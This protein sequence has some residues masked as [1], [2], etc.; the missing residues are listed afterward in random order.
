MSSD[1][2]F[3]PP[4]DQAVDEAAMIV[5]AID[6][7]SAFSACFNARDLA[8][9]DA[10]LHFPH[11]ILSGE[12][13]VV[14]DKPGQLPARFFD[15]LEAATGWH[16]SIYQ[17]KQAVLVSPRKVHLVVDYTRNRRD[18][19]VIS[20]HQNLWVVTQD[21]GRWGIKLRSY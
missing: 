5:A 8:G 12:Q 20:A 4:H 11:I 15:D 13:L 17:R 1:S 16:Q 19:S 14:W 3:N 10:H 6:C 9:M 21:D 18:G 2:V 7:V